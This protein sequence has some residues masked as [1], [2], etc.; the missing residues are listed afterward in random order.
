MR[1]KA[2]LAR[3]QQ[4]DTGNRQE[5]ATTYREL[6]GVRSRAEWRRN[7]VIALTVYHSMA[8]M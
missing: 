5:W 2:F 1:L 8:E 3:C 7:S 4:Q 6:T